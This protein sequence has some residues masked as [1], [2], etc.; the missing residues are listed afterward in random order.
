[1]SSTVFSARKSNHRYPDNDTLSAELFYNLKP[2]FKAPPLMDASYYLNFTR[3]GDWE[4]DMAWRKMKGNRTNSYSLPL[5]F[6][7]LLSLYSLSLPLSV[8][9]SL[10][11]SFSQFFII[12]LPPSLS[13][14]VSPSLPFFPPS[15]SLSVSVLS[16]CVLQLQNIPRFSLAQHSK[17]RATL[18]RNAQ[19]KLFTFSPNGRKRC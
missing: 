11:L 14:S 9:L 19:T 1:M 2:V 6:S 3:E 10:P 13:H 5:S 7:L 17:G 8:S 16:L 18:A 12:Y 4:F 15:P